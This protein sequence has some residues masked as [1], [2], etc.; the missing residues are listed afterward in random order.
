MLDG[1]PLIDAPADADDDLRPS[2][3]ALLGEVPVKAIAH[4]TGGGLLENIPRVLPAGL[5]VDAA[6]RQLDTARRYSIGS[7]RSASRRARCTGRS[8]AASA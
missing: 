8:T 4:V 7:R 5:G 3:A 1:E 2:R 6:T